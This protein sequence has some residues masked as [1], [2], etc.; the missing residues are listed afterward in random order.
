MGKI[1][2]NYEALYLKKYLLE[3]D[4]PRKDDSEFISLRVQA[5]ADEYESIRLAGGTPDAAQEACIKV[6][7]EGLE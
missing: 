5:A 4:D 2:F 1:D 7:M 3:H 6:L